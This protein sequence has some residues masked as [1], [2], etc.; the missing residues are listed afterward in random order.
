MSTSSR[1]DALRAAIASATWQRSDNLTH[2]AYVEARLTNAVTGDTA[3]TTYR[4]VAV[5]G[6]RGKWKG[7]VNPIPKD[8]RARS[9]LATSFR[10]L[11]DVKAALVEHCVEMDR[12]LHLI[13]TAQPSRSTTR[14]S[15]T[16]KL[17]KE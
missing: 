2:I 12:Q 14:P 5:L 16:T 1:E 11:V 13:T 17:T 9:R 10:S 4:L 15:P 8:V 6:E 3:L 7:F